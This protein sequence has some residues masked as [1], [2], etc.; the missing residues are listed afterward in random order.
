MKPYL[1]ISALVGIGL[2]LV[3]CSSSSGEASL[4]SAPA[5]VI[6]AE[7]KNVLSVGLLATGN[8]KDDMGNPDYV[9][10]LNGEF[11]T[12]NNK[13]VVRSTQLC[14]YPITAVAIHFK[15]FEENPD[16]EEPKLIADRREY[17]ENTAELS[18]KVTVVCPAESTLLVGFSVGGVNGA[19]SGL[20]STGFT[21]RYK[22]STGEVT[23]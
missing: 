6:A 3:G 12:D 21:G 13:V 16:F 20:D 10:T 7:S 22:C 23:W 18:D 15:V 11:E 1:S 14:S 2:A 17:Q 9:C 8:P 19:L 5:Q 4:D